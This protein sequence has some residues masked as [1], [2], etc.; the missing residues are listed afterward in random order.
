MPKLPL[1]ALLSSLALL[2]AASAQAQ[3]SPTPARPTDPAIE[4]SR[5]NQTIER[6]RIEDAGSRIDELRVGGQTQSI[7][8]QP[9]GDLPP[10]EVK[11]VDARGMPGPGGAR[12]WNFL[13]F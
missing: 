10:Y 2:A 12:T 13:R 3:N 6:I 9:K 8:V 7:M 11:P 5:N 1:T 4:P